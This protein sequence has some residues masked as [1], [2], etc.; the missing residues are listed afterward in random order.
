MTGYDDLRMKRE[1]IRVGVEAY[2]Q[3]PFYLN[4]LAH[5]IINLI[6]SNNQKEVPAA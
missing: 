6:Q 2:I 1:S 5:T 4:E 3:K